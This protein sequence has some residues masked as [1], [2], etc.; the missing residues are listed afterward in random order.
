MAHIIKGGAS[1]YQIVH[2]RRRSAPEA[3]AAR[4]LQDGLWRMTGV[5]LPVRWPE[6][7]LADRP[8]ILVGSGTQPDEPGL[9]DRDSYEILPQGDDLALRGSGERGT[10]YAVVAFLEWLGV[11]FYGPD[12]VVMP[13]R[14]SV[15]LPA[16]LMRSTAA[17]SYRHV[18][19]P[20]AQ[21]PEWAV[22]W[23]LNVHN[24]RDARWG[25]NAAAHSIGHSFDALVPPGVHFEKHPEYF[26]LVDGSRRSHRQQLCC[27]NP[28]VA[29][30]ACESMARWIET[31][32]DRRIFAVGMNDWRNWCECP[33]C[34]EADEREGTRVGQ[35][36][37]LVN[38]VAERFPDRII[39]TLAYMW[40]VDPPRHMRA[41]DNVLIVL[42][43]NEGC[44]SHP[45]CACEHNERFYRRLEGW[46]QRADHIL[47][48]DYYVN[49]H[50][51]LMPAPNLRRIQEDI[52]LYSEFGIEGMFC[53]GSAV[54]GGQFEGL[55]Q[56]VLARMLWDTGEDV[57]TLADEWLHNVYGDES[58]QCILQYLRMLHEHVDATR[59]H[60]LSYGWEQEIQPSIFTPQILARGKELW[61]KAEE[62]AD[63]ANRRKVFAARAPEMCSR[64]FHAGMT[65]AV[66]GGRLRPEPAPDVELRDRFVEAAILGGA[67]HLVE[68][69]AAPEDFARNYGRDYEAVVLESELLRAIVLPELGGRIYSLRWKPDDLELLRVTDFVRFVNRQ[70]YRAGYEFA[71]DGATSRGTTATYRVAERRGDTAV[72]LTAE[73]DDGPLLRTEFALDD[74]VM[75]VSH[76][77][78]NAGPQ[79]VTVQPRTHPEWRYDQF[80][81]GAQI[82]LMAADGSW[83]TV[84]LNP[85]GRPAR[86]LPFTGEDAP[87]GCWRLSSPGFPLAI[88]ESFSL[89]RLD[90]AGVAFY[91]RSG[92]LDTRLSLK[93]HELPPGGTWQFS[94]RWRFIP[95]DGA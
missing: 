17:F 78:E 15:E 5:R 55:R 80:G 35:L 87:A 13:R 54:R 60:V 79:T 68:N 71:V 92:C 91:E 61:D 9:W 67:A 36:L 37:T 6:Q 76:R 16:E 72:V 90:S 1:R 69:S 42:C 21:E 12:E 65:Y 25:P 74:N 33:N 88:E 93:P 62:A 7:R 51:Y 81:P 77:I 48:W 50:S 2:D 30:V 59:A 23:K 31:Y 66:H 49:Y 18:F 82:H 63:D 56:Y 20:T 47:I 8:A 14:A 45:L 70:P 40:A 38:R 26:S 4:M 64:L 85:E 57:W 11:R 75:S 58:G 19:Y 73:L 27:T 3:Y 22:R 94:L 44:F 24:G 34:A 95:S 53:Q 41:R 28:D 52:R 84:P 10:L 29:D 46:R 83:R 32:P 43:D 86:D 89:D 39:A